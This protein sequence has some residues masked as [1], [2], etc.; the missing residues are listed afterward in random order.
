MQHL[1][2]LSFQLLQSI[3]SVLNREP[4]RIWTEQQL[5]CWMISEMEG[6]EEYRWKGHKDW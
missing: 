5:F 2:V 6:L 3:E 1:Q 4:Y